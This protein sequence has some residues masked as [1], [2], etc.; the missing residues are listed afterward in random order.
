M[1]KNRTLD[2]EP[3]AKMPQ[4]AEY[5][6]GFQEVLPP[7]I[8]EWA[9]AVTEQPIEAAAEEAV[10]AMDFE[11]AETPEAETPEAEASER[12]RLIA[13]YIQYQ[14]NNVEDPDALSNRDLCYTIL[15]HLKENVKKGFPLIDENRE[16]AD[17]VISILLQDIYREY[18][19]VHASDMTVE[20]M[21]K[22]LLAVLNLLPVENEE[23]EYL[24]NY[25]LEVVIYF[26]LDL[27][28]CGLTEDDLGEYWSDGEFEEDFPA[29]AAAA[30]VTNAGPEEAYCLGACAPRNDSATH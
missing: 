25:L 30:P 28:E 7:S 18:I 13:I 22:D 20:Q 9:A 14:L 3:P 16:N 10:A 2:G 27:N 12:D 24:V 6:E 21:I 5:L 23:A 15:K 29:A 19:P 17:C 8:L 11:D 26:G 4:L 1:A